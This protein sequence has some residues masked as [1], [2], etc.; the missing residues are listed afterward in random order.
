MSGT[1]RINPAEPVGQYGWGGGLGTSWRCDPAE[2]MVTILLTQRLWSSP[3]PLAVC[4][5]FWTQAY[6]AIEY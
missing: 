1:R 2:D 5:D 4:V 6:A 3:A